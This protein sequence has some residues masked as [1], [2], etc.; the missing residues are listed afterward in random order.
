M[1]HRITTSAVFAV[2]IGDEGN[3]GYTVFDREGVVLIARTNDGVVVLLQNDLTTSFEAT[4]L[5]DDTVVG[6]T[7]VWDDGDSQQ[8]VRTFSTGSGGGNT[9]TIYD[10]ELDATWGG[11]SSDS[12][13]DL[14]TAE[15]IL[16]KHVLDIAGW[17][18]ATGREQ[19]A[20]LRMATIQIEA[21]SY[22]GSRCNY[23]QK[24]Q[25]PRYIDWTRDSRQQDDLQRA[26]A[27][28][29]NELLSVNKEFRRHA[30]NIQLGLRQVGESV[31]PIREQYTYA[32]SAIGITLCIESER[33]MQNYRDSK[34]LVRG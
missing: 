24:L 8:A 21:G 15:S 10:S 32:L 11:F 31:G 16:Q 20:A 34:R 27:M 25:F 7:I 33:I 12:F 30:R 19:D 18:A 4:F 6:G 9:P 28:Q 3:I 22:I 29:A 2:N 13:V 14:V 1:S 17:S 5:V 26:T 23:Q